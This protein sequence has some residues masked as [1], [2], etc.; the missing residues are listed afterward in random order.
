MVGV[1]GSVTIGDGV[2][3]GGGTIIKDHLTIGAGVRIGGHSGVM[4][5]IPPGETWAGSPAQD[6]GATFR[7]YAAIR[8]LPELFREIDQLRAP[9]GG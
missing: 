2:M 5:D 6:R 3:I 4:H 1:G 7:E 9:G 8:K